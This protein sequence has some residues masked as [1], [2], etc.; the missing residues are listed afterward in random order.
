VSSSEKETGRP[1]FRSRALLDTIPPAM[2]K[3]YSSAT[4]FKFLSG[5]DEKKY[6]YNKKKGVYKE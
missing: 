3:G 1:I 4:L 5:K 2:E 6:R